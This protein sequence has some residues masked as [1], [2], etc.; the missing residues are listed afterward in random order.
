MKK[1][2]KPAAVSGCCIYR[3]VIK[4]YFLGF[5]RDINPERLGLLI[6]W[7]SIGVMFFWKFRTET[8]QNWL[9]GIP[10]PFAVLS[11][12]LHNVSLPFMMYLVPFSK[13]Q[14]EAY[15]QKL[16]YVKVAVP[17]LFAGL[18][19]IAAAVFGV[20]SVYGLV[21]QL[22]TVFCVAYICGMLWDNMAHST[23]GR[24]VYGN[25]KEFVQI[26]LMLCTVD[27]SA[28]FAACLYP[29]SEA[30]FWVM[31]LI[32]M[33]IMLPI[34]RGVRKKWKIIRHNFADYEMLSS[35]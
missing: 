14:R 13:E 4:D 17:M 28:M 27:G 19:D 35:M 34:I 25:L 26:P 7:V 11:G 32:E 10:I 20:V 1:K 2:A 29:V 15:I 23:K 9:I 3:Q 24:K 30:V 33:V 12:A 8:F 21:L 18:C 31:F 16:L 5:C 22:V 6:A